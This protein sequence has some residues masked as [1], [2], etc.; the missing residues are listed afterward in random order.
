MASARGRHSGGAFRRSI[1]GL[2]PPAR[3]GAARHGRRMQPDIPDPPRGR[4]ILVAYDGSRSARTALSWAVAES[5]SG[6]PLR[7]AHVMRWPLPEL[8][9][10]RLPGS[11]HDRGR[12]RESATDLV[13]AAVAWS[14]GLA[15]QVDIGGE[16]LTGDAIELLAKLSTE[17]SMLVVGA[18]G[19]TASPQV[20][21]GSTASELTRR[22]TVPVAVIR[23]VTEDS[24]AGNVI[25]GVDGSAAGG[26]AIR[27]GFDVAARR[28]LG[29]VAVHAW[30]DLPLEA[31]GLRADVEGAGLADAA[32]LL[33]EQLAAARRLHPQV[34]VDEMVVLDRPARALLDRAVGAALVVVSRH[35]RARGTATPLGSV[36]HA[37]LHY[38]PC[39]VLLTS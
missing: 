38:A 23:N 2:A 19:Q 34:P 17:A 7:L 30:S 39:P 1:A 14:K 28:G 29:V 8:D 36:S 37:V 33:T 25:I 21:L 10:L 31:L 35:G 16:A 18:S 32:A 9:G 11:V 13:A 3:G 6:R 24:A 15:P 4:P 26:A 27:A 5:A 20:L 22:V 12:A